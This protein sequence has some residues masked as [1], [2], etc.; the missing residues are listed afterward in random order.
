MKVYAAV[1]GLW[2]NVGVDKNRL[3]KKK[4]KE[5]TLCF[6]SCFKNVQLIL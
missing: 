1:H 5:E 6:D 2:L 3:V 4:K